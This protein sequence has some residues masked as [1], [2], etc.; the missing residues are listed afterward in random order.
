[1]STAV[2]VVQVALALVILNV[3]LLRVN[4]ATGY[5]GGAAQNMKEEFA[6]YGLPPAMFYVVGALKLACA[7]ALLVGVWAPA[8]T[9]PGAAGLAGLMA[10]AAV[11]H[12]KVKDPPKKAM[13][14]LTLLALSLFVVFA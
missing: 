13:P 6:V 9:V 7:V 5:R 14:A 1:M 3:W 12:V 2:I 10:G 4:R 8:A 11:M